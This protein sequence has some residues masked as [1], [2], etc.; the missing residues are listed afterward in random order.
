MICIEFDNAPNSF[1]YEDNI[2]IHGVMEGNSAVN[3]LFMLNFG[4]GK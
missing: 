4:K 3:D 2:C 1:I